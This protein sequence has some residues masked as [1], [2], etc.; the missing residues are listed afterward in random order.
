MLASSETPP[1][2]LKDEVLGEILS[3]ELTASCAMSVSLGGCLGILGFLKR[4][5]AGVNCQPFE[6]QKA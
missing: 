5:L 2:S 4:P 3:G 6:Q 1:G